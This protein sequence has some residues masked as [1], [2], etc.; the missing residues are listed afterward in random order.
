MGSEDLNGGKQLLGEQS[1]QRQQKQ[2]HNKRG[3]EK[4]LVC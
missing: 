1:G 3:D 4:C 2:S